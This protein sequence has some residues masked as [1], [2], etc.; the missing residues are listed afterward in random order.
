MFVHILATYLS[1]NNKSE[2][3]TST[4]KK[5]INEL[6]ELVLNK[7]INLG[8]NHKQDFKQVLNKWPEVKTKI[9]NAFKLSASE[10]QTPKAQNSMSVNQR[11]VGQVN[12]ITPSVTS[13][14]SKAP[15]IQ[16]KTFGNF[17]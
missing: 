15:K 16:L 1:E 14:Q 5:Y 11:Q 17:K 2:S 10:Q 3:L 12:V 7:L 4:S 13:S 8:T 6:N 9:E